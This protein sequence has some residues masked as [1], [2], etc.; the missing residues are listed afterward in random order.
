MASMA[1]VTIRTHQGNTMRP[2]LASRP[3]LSPMAVALPLATLVLCNIADVATTDKLLSMGATEMNPVAGWLIANNALL[4]TKLL[5]VLV[6]G[7]A[8]VRVPPRRWVLPAMWSVATL[9]ASIITF[10]MVQ[11]TLF[12]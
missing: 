6:I 8:A 1:A 5:I 9:Y 11:L 4:L 12:T 2:G 10:H 3:R 7:V